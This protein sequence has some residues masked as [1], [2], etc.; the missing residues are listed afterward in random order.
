MSGA[1]QQNLA[2]ENWDLGDRF[3]L[4]Q[5]FSV[6]FLGWQ[7]D[8]RP[9]QGLTFQAPLAAVEGLVRTSYVEGRES[10]E[11]ITF[12]L[13]YCA[14]D[15]NHEDAKLTFRS[16]IDEPARVLL[17]ERWQLETDG[18]S[19]QLNGGVEPGIYEAIYHARNSP[20]AGLGLAAIRDFA[21]YLKYGPKGGTL[22]EEP[23]LVQRV[24]GFGY[25]QSGRFLREFVR[26]GFN[27][28]EK[29]RAVFDGL[30]ISSAGAGGGSF[31]HR[32]AMPGEAGNSVLSILRP[33]DLPPFDDDGLLAKAV[34][35]HV[36][37]KIFYTFSS[38]EYWARAGSLTH[39]SEDGKKDI[40][41]AATSRLYF[42]AGTPHS[43]GPF[44]SRDYQYHANFAQQRWALRALVLDLDG[45]IRSAAEPPASRYPKLA[46]GELVPRAA[47]RFP[48]I[49]SLPFPDYMPSVWT[50]AYGP[51]YERTRIITKEPPSLGKKFT[52]LVPQV[53]VDGNDVLGIRIP[54]VAVPIG[55]YTGWNI[56]LPQLRSLEYLAGLVGSFEPFAKTSEERE[57]S[58]DPRLS[59]AERYSS[60]QDYLDRVQSAAR[61]LVSQ[62]FMLAE[63]V[64][65]AIRRASAMWDAIVAGGSR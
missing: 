14:A 61:D 28:D 52:V 27:G 36:V 42:I 24:I 4:E 8:V 56:Y 13:F 37:P 59:I 17:R 20:V 19:V 55:T 38:T 29:G 32:F 34:K 7:F 10:A 31:N 64:E 62:R 46:K 6:A 39:T 3:L 35:A 44:Y 21:S 15:R 30:M 2:P 51:Q 18:C 41:L 45:W 53:D 1:V 54:E 23:A 22:R 47:V 40:P 16:R 43:G 11:N 65:A 26:D 57:K 50:M 49:P 63:D 58:G 12:P 9:A 25:S 48:K 33:V 60:K 5:G